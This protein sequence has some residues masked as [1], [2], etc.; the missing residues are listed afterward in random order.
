MATVTRGSS[1]KLEDIL[2]ADAAGLL[3]WLFEECYQAV[4]DFA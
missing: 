2:G 3:D 1:A 4:G